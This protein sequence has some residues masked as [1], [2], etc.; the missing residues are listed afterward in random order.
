MKVAKNAYA[1]YSKQ[2]LKRAM[3]KA[4]ISSPNWDS[5]RKINRDGVINLIPSRSL[6]D[7]RIISSVLAFD[8][9]ILS[10][11]LTTLSNRQHARSMI[12]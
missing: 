4:I 10:E 12:L 6:V 8:T 1:S 5:P 3:G 2:V 11:I 9:A 7:S